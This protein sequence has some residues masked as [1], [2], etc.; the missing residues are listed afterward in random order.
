MHHCWNPSP[1][2]CVPKGAPT[3]RSDCILCLLQQLAA[4]RHVSVRHARPG[5]RRA[6]CADAAATAVHARLSK[7][8]HH[9]AV[10]HRMRVGHVFQHLEHLDGRL[11]ARAQQRAGAGPRIPAQPV[12]AAPQLLDEVLDGRRG[13]LLQ[14]RLA[15]QRAR[16]HTLPLTPKAAAGARHPNVSSGRHP[17]ANTCTGS[18]GGAT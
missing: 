10:Q 7:A 12:A 15:L 9:V 13:R 14:V 6:R 17:G 5:R 4:R 16:V 2:V 1:S 11:P 18:S 8:L 3:H